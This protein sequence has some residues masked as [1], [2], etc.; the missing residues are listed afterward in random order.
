MP[1]APLPNWSKAKDGCEKL[2]TGSAAKAHLASVESQCEQDFIKTLAAKKI[3]W[4]GATDTDVEGSWKWS[5]PGGQNFWTGGNPKTGGKAVPGKFTGWMSSQPDSAGT[6]EQDCLLL[7]DDGEWND[8]LCSKTAQYLCETPAIQ[9]GAGLIVPTT[10][11]PI[12]AACSSTCETGWLDGGDCLCYKLQTALATWSNSKAACNAA[13]TGASLISLTSKD[14]ET[15]VQTM[16]GTPEDFWTG[17]NDAANNDKEFRWDV[18]N[19][20]FWTRDPAKD[21]SCC[22]MPG[23]Y[24]NW[25]EA[26]VKQPNHAALQNCVKMKYKLT[27]GVV[28]KNGWDDLSCE[29]PLK[30]VCQYSIK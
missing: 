10:P 1:P 5:K 28:E 12:V 6:Q 11:K 22:A 3:T 30:S 16:L 7:Q 26:G 19:V 24:N 18:G 27:N 21:P 9:G 13:K 8:Q 4:L 25:Y 15:K 29:K 14:I 20:L 2:W 17:G 23:Q